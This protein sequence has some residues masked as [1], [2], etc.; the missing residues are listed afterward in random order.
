VD[1]YRGYI[2]DGITL[3]IGCGTG[4]LLVPLFQAGCNIYGMDI[5]APM[6]EKLKSQLPSA[7]RHRVVQWSTLETPYPV[8]DE[9]FDRVIIPFS[10]FGLMHEGHIDDLDENKVF[11]EFYR[12]LRPGG[13]VIL[14]D[15]R[16]YV[17]DKSGNHK[18][19]IAQQELEGKQDKDME[20]HVKDN[21][22]FLTFKQHHPKHG[23]IKEEWIST[24]TLKKTRLIPALVIRE[25]EI[26]FTRL[27]DHQVLEKQ[28]EIIPVWDAEDYPALGK[29]AGFEHVKTETTP[30]FHVS[31]TVAHI[32]R[33]P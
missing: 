19:S 16:I 28:H 9:S 2:Q 27:R 6:L 31:A 3:E 29:D 30:K 1:Y 25:R 13:L 5:S 10:S 20:G 24:F 22:L 32:F 18:A 12:I 7:D 17:H 23:E 26:V 8:D 15:A 21:K 33:K 14:N 11:H 4:R